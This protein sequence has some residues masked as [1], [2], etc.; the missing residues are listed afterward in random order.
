[1]IDAPPTPTIGDCDVTRHAD[2]ATQVRQI[3]S[4]LGLP[5]VIE[6]HTH[7]MPK[8]VVDKVWNYFDSAGPLVGR[9]WPIRYRFNGS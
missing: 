3:W 1:M 4:A 2:E 9:P 7:C 5:G 6:V 8:S